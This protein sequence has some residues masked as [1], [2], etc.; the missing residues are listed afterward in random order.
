MKR[1]AA[2]RTTRVVNSA[3]F[4]SGVIAIVYAFGEATI[5]W[6]NGVLWDDLRNVRGC[7]GGGRR[8]SGHQFF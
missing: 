8:N 7:I 5:L 3:G 1:I 4:L 2:E 6:P